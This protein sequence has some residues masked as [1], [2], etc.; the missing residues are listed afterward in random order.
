MSKEVKCFDV[1]SMVVNE[2]TSQFAPLFK[3]DDE[4]YD[5]LKQYCEAFDKM[6]EEFQGEAFGID[7]DDETMTVSVS[8]T[9]PDMIIDKPHHLCCELA[10]RALQIDFNK[11]DEYEDMVCT[12]FMFPGIWERA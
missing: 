4:K 5:I 2:A 8:I 12:T 3:V 9:T 6:A 11:D 7:I 10:K 1:V